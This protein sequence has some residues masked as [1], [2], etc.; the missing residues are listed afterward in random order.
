MQLYGS[1]KENRTGLYTHTA[2]YI[3]KY[4]HENCLI[5]SADVIII[6]LIIS[7]TVTVLINAE[8][9]QNSDETIY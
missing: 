4:I 1:I 9:E 3:H 5:K 8:W 6:I 2:K 7:I